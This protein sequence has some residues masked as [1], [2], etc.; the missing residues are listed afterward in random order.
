MTGRVLTFFSRSIKK[1]IICLTLLCTLVPILCVT[2]ISYANSTRAME[3]KIL[4][5]N[6]KMMEWSGEHIKGTVKKLDEIVFNL[7]ADRSFIYQLS[8]G[9]NEEKTLSLE[10]DNT[11]IN[12]LYSLIYSN[13][14][15]NSIILYV[16]CRKKIY[17][18]SNQISKSFSN[19]IWDG[20]AWYGCPDA[21]ASNL[22]ANRSKVRINASGGPAEIPENKGISIVRRV[23]DF[24]SSDELFLIVLD[25]KWNALRDMFSLL[26]SDESSTIVIADSHWNAV[27]SPNGGSLGEDNLRDISGLIAARGSQSGFLLSGKD[28]C[29]F[30]RELPGDLSLIKFVPFSVVNLTARENLSLG[31]FIGA[32]FLAVALS[33]S[34]PVTI[35][36]VNPIVKLSREMEEIQQNNFEVKIDRF[37]EDEVGILQRSFVYMMNQIRDLI[38]R[39]YRVNIEKRTAQLKALQ[40]QINPHFLYNSLQMIGGIAV[41]RGVPEIY[42]SIKALSDMFRYII[43]TQYDYVTIREEIQHVNNYLRIQTQRYCDKMNADI[44]IDSGIMEYILP[45]LCIQ[46]LIENTFI[47]GFE[48]KPGLWKIGITGRLEHGDV[49][50]TITDNGMGIRS[51]KLREIRESLESDEVFYR[52]KGL[53]IRNINARIRLMFGH[54]Y[55]VEVESMENAGTRV[56]LKIP[57]RRSEEGS[58]V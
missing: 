30:N 37:Y 49:F 48:N 10:S 36:T 33:V 19:C 40:A 54:G 20:L 52:D 8:A 25:V 43:K 9:M 21:G 22:V 13:S 53:G 50:F 34:L 2:G 44:S 28:Y 57:A 38:N 1:R 32:A 29:F 27:Y 45:K 11:I 35:H 17:Y 23:I 31:L 7:A 55:G 5:S 56:V 3:N 16:G 14:D 6:Q 46:P 51:E 58:D 18:V 26:D 12:K 41:S 42:H 47:H 4:S 39:E 24:T 15:L